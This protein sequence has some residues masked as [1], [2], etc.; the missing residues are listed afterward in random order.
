MIRK[1]ER[2]A[3]R[4]ENAGHY[5]DGVKEK[6]LCD[7]CEAG[8]EVCA[9]CI[10]IIDYY[11]DGGSDRCS[12]TAEQEKCVYYKPMEYCPKCGKRLAVCK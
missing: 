5:A 11:E 10:K 2:W 3:G 8:H 12:E 7:W 4:L 6:K 9:A 1:A